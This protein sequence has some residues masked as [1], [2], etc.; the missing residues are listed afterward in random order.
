MIKFSKLKTEET[1]LICFKV[2]TENP[3]KTIV[4]TNLRDLEPAP[5]YRICSGVCVDPSKSSEIRKHTEGLEGMKQLSLL[6]SDR[7]IDC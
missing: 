6:V 4:I 7:E 1:F 3:S 5:P 2:S